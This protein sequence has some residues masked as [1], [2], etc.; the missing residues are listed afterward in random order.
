MK[1]KDNYLLRMHLDI[2]AVIES[3]IA[4]AFL[5]E[6]VFQEAIYK[7]HLK[8]CLLPSKEKYFFIL[9]SEHQ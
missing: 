9:N 3:L 6:K 7:N 1:I 8:L 4:F 5:E 2:V